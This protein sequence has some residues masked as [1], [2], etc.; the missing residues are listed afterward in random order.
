[1]T[2]AAPR[3]SARGA[4]GARGSGSGRGTVGRALGFSTVNTAL[5]KLAS[6]VI[7]IALARIL[8]PE[9]FGTFAVALIALMAVLSFNEL[10]VSLAIVRWP[11]DPARLAPTVTTVA[12]ASSLALAALMAWAAGPFATAMGDPGAA[13]PV[14]LLAL[15]I[16]VNGVVATPAALL[17]RT[18]RQDQRLVADQVNLWL[19]AVVSIGVALAGVGAMSL[20]V[21]RLTGA[22]VSAVLFLRFSPLPLRLGLDRTLVPALLRFGLPLAA[23]SLVVFGVGFADQL[24]VGS[25][26]GPTLLGAYVL[27]FNLA[28]WPVQLLSTP[29]RQVTPPLFA[30]QQHDPALV[31]RTLVGISRP[32]LALAVPCCV[33]LAVCAG[34]VV[35]VVYGD[36]W[37][38]AAEPLRWLALA[39]VVRILAELLYDYLVIV[40]RTSSVLGVQ[41]VWLAALVPAVVVGTRLGGLAGAALAQLAVGVVV[42]C[43]AYAVALRRTR[44]PVGRL[45]PGL[46]LPA[47]AGVALLAVVSLPGVRG[48]PDLLVLAVCAAATVA[49]WAFLLARLRPELGLL[50]GRPE[51][52]EPSE[53]SAPAVPGLPA[54]A[55]LPVPPAPP[56]PA[57]HRLME[58]VR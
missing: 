18:F 43:P 46:V 33:A 10:G 16:V 50:R 45:L 53:P 56:A 36:A 40:G 4:R 41:V 14:R 27:A 1:M 26:L 17:Q 48:G 44:T 57:T 13:L 28:S 38:A 7:G 3:H 37:S 52:P 25:V 11:G 8:G 29:L 39:A 34:P 12:L 31:R 22:V 30:R 9:E 5:S 19:G 21:G 58:E 54:P 6:L 49:A 2:R 23:A 32:L 55:A 20:V 42:V 24:A 47:V 15:C 35:R 51:P